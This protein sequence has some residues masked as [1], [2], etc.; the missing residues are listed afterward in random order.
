MHLSTNA[1][2]SVFLGTVLGTEG[3][4]W[5]QIWNGKHIECVRVNSAIY[6]AAMR[7]IFYF[8]TQQQKWMSNKNINSSAVWVGAA[9]VLF[10][11]TH[12]QASQPQW[13]TLQIDAQGTLPGCSAHRIPTT[14]IPL[15][16]HNDKDTNRQIN[17]PIIC[18]IFIRSSA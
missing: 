2:Y 6:R 14:T 13:T 17:H 16:A 11:V 15:F 7:M 9:N 4:Q 10:C 5:L 1:C 18:F 8:T 12:T 3:L